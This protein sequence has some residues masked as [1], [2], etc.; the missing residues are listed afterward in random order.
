MIYGGLEREDLLRWS[1]CEV[2]CGFVCFLE[3]SEVGRER[4]TELQ[5]LL[6]LFG[7]IVGTV[8]QYR[9]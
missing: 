1:A 3:D 9:Y 2:E 4:V 6:F 7:E 5:D 8:E